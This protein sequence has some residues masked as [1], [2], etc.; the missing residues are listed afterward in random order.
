M[1]SLRRALVWLTL[2]AACAVGA[3]AQSPPAPGAIHP[4]DRFSANQ[5]ENWARTYGTPLYVYDGDRILRNYREIA[6]AFAKLYPRSKVLYALKANTNL[7]IVALLKGAGA[8]AEVVSGGEVAIARRLGYRGSEIFFTSTSKSPAELRLALDEG[9]TINIDSLDELEQVAR[10]SEG[11]A[12]P[13]RISFRLNPDVDPHTNA[14]VATGI[15]QSKFGLHLAEGIAL[16]A[17]QRALELPQLELVGLHCHIGSQITSAGPFR[18]EAKEVLTFVQQIQAELGVHLQFLD[19]G[20]GLGIPYRDGELVIGP[21]EWAEAL[22]SEL[23]SALVD[24]PELW[25]EPGRAL[26]AD[27]GLLLTRVNSVKSTPSATFVNIDAGFNTLIRPVL[28]DAYHRVRA[29]GKSGPGH[30]VDIAGVICE[31]GDILATGRS[32][33]SLTQGDLL[34]ILDTGAYGFSMA[35]EYNSR[36]LPAELLIRGDQA[37][38]IREAGTVEDLL[39]HQL[40]PPDL[41]T[42]KPLVP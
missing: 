34:M 26:V 41:Q 13:T 33:P 8:G 7:A 16:R 11:R 3:A 9:V 27:A 24:P 30:P 36:P 19:F 35:S 42:S 32:L 20:G 29:V 10:L 21:E 38:L 31:T 2:A 5:L 39:R 40:L 28:Y 22:V 25:V 15:L 12:A 14:K 1:P 4:A 18:L 17:V 37:E 6:G 23:Q